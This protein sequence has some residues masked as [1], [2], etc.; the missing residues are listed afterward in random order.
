MRKT[1]ILGI[2]VFPVTANASHRA[3]LIYSHIWLSTSLHD[4][5]DAQCFNRD[6]QG[7]MLTI[8]AALAEVCLQ[9]YGRSCS[10]M[11]FMHGR[12]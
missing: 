5:T 3:N 7:L 4:A 11:D 10:H 8:V 12:L 9:Y 2:Q 1:Q 6:A